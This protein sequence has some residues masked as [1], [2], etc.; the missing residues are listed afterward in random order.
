[1][2]FRFEGPP[3]RNEGK[4][5]RAPAAGLAAGAFLFGTQGGVLPVR[6]GG[7]PGRPGAVTVL[8]ARARVILWQIARFSKHPAHKGDGP[9][10]GILMERELPGALKHK[11][12]RFQQPAGGRVIQ[13]G[14][15]GERR[16]GAALH[17]KLHQGLHAFARIAPAVPGRVKAIA[18]VVGLPFGAEPHIAD[19]LLRPAHG[20][21]QAAGGK[22][23]CQRLCAGRAGG[24]RGVVHGIGRAAEV[25]PDGQQRRPI[26][27]LQAADVQPFG[28]ENHKAAPFRARRPLIPAARPG[29]PRP[30]PTWR[31]EWASGFGPAR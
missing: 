10:G 15:C 14:A 3:I 16:H 23:L 22:L 30:R 25:A 1:M 13:R 7:R 6:R 19:E 4:K 18:H 9:A 11:A 17:Q 5:N 27:F 31:P 12:K 24:Q 8:T 2:L 26:G 29:S 21:K 28:V 20:E